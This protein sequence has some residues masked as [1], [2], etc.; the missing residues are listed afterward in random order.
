MRLEGVSPL[1]RFGEESILGEGM[2]TGGLWRYHRSTYYVAMHQL[3]VSARLPASLQVSDEKEQISSEA[4]EAARVAC[5]KYLLKNAGKEAY[6]IRV[7]VHPFHVLRM[8]KML[9][10]AGADRLSQGTSKQSTA[11]GK[12]Y[13]ISVLSL[14]VI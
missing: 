10:C 11:H 12:G 7:R 13:E 14:T 8:S 5:N 9:S 3:N 2:G 4:L 1:G 6:H